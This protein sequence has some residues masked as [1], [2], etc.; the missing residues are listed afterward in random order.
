VFTLFEEDDMKKNERS[1]DL[2]APSGSAMLQAKLRDVLVDAA[3]TGQATT[4][5]GLLRV[6][7]DA[8]TTGSITWEFK[9][10]ALCD[11]ELDE[12]PALGGLLAGYDPET[13]VVIAFVDAG[14]SFFRV[15][16]DSRDVSR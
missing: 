1:P 15:S 8:G 14:A 3:M 7:C 12:W 5:R 16:V 4:G 11:E 6:L 9:P 10:I 13:E 2:Y